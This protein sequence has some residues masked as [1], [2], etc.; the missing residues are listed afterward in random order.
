MNWILSMLNQAGDLLIVVLGFSLIIVIHELG[1]FI[2]A[3]WAGIRVLVFAVGFGPA[4]FSYRKGLGFRRGSSEAEFLRLADKGEPGQRGISPSEYRLNALPFGGYVKMLGQDDANPAARS[5]EPDSY[6]NC[7]VWKRMVVISAGVIANIITAGILFVAVF[8]LG[9]RTEPPRI[10]IVSPGSPAATTMPTNAVELGISRPGLRPGDEIVSLDG[11]APLS[12]NDVT[13]ASVM[14]RRGQP[15]TMDIRRQGVNGI[16]H[17]AIKPEVDAA[18]KMQFIGA[19]PA[20][21]TL[22]RPANGEHDRAE[23]ARLLAQRGV[24]GLD[25]GMTLISIDGREATTA[26]DLNEAAERSGG[27]PIKAVF[28]SDAG[29]ELTVEIPTRP[30]LAQDRFMI[31]ENTPVE[32]R[33]VLGLLPVLSVAAV[34]DDSAG[35]AAGLKPGDVFVQLGEA[36]WPSVPT[37]IA[38]IRG[39]AGSKIRVVVS[40]AAANGHREEVDLGMVPVSGRGQ[41]GFNLGDSADIGPWV[42][43][44]LPIAGD[45][46]P[47]HPDL[48]PGSRIVAVDGKPTAT[49]SEVRHRLSDAMSG[50]S[51]ATTSLTVELPVVS[52]EADSARPT[53]SV[54]WTLTEDHKTRL[55][56]GSWAPALEPEIFFEPEQFE[57]KATTPLGALTMGVRETRRVMIT[58]YITIARLFEGTVKVEHLRGP[59]GIADAGT[60]LAKRGYVWLL[61]FMA[62]ISINLAVVNFLPI[63]IADGGHFLFLLYEQITGKPVSV[64]VQNIAAIAGLVLLVTMFVIVTFHD[65]A[66][67]FVG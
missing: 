51:E 22:L 64:A 59:V 12:F 25:P 58:T 26:F 5:D 18:T 35:A 6:Q 52:R 43:T 13:L 44:S 46:A 38:T 62:I 65:I 4:L 50:S 17:F 41:I 67:L 54:S 30:W 48:S 49:L 8:M 9:L 29:K 39:N 61:F 15:I 45:R 60:Q 36:E 10:G 2:A 14:A 7:K 34:S 3:K 42:G 19:G 24:T 32:A 16:L 47:A 28:R 57:L 66:R 56:A 33:H 1:H 55:T 40:R 53:E 63:P 20:A 11:E 23:Y 21:S 37:G 27:S 31:G